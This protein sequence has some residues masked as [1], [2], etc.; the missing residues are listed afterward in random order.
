MQRVDI[1]PAKSRQCSIKQTDV[2]L[3]GCRRSNPA[4]YWK[5]LNDQNEIERTSK[6][7]N[8][9]VYRD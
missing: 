3:G 5:G 9:Y 8:R 4:L 1:A 2:Q 6:R 7:K